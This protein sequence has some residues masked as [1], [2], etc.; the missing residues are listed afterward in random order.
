MMH[1]QAFPKRSLSTRLAQKASCHAER[2]EIMARGD[3]LDQVF[4]LLT[5]SRIGKSA[6]QGVERPK[7]QPARLLSGGDFYGTT[8]RR[9][10]GLGFSATVSQLTVDSPQLGLEIALIT[11]E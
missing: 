8:Q 7:L 9:R 10:G 4:K 11:A 3:S 1:P 6:G 5:Q 2:R